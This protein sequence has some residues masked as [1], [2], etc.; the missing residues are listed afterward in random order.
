[1]KRMSLRITVAI[2]ALLLFAPTML[3]QVP[4]TPRPDFRISFDRQMNKVVPGGSA[5]YHVFL[6]PLDGFTGT[7]ML[8]CDMFAP[9]ERYSISPSKVTLGGLLPIPIV[10]ITITTHPRSPGGM[11]HFMFTARAVGPTPHSRESHSAGLSLMVMSK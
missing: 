5:I 1:M 10:T 3:A 7:V 2:A 8:D 4:P 6:T 11:T 9:Y